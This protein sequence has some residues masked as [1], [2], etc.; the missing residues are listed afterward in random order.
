MP[1]QTTKR[2]NL[3][4]YEGYIRRRW[5]EGQNNVKAL[6]SEI[7]AYGYTGSYTILANFLSAYPRL[8]GDP[9]LPP[10]SKVNTYS[11]RRIS[12]LLNQLPE[13]WSANEQAFLTHLLSQHDS[14]RQVQ[15]LSEQF[16]QLM[17]AKSSEGLAKWCEEAEEVPAYTSFVRGLRQDYAAVEQAFESKWSNGQTEG[18]VNRLKTL[19]RQMYGRAGFDLLRRRVL[20]RNC[21]HH[22]D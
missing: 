3:L 4:L 13:T 14:I 19:K 2:S 15:K 6:L 17:K 16:R 11:S 22:P 5:L 10:A 7:K 9:I 20:F 21:T 18:Q 1:R 12:R 8:E